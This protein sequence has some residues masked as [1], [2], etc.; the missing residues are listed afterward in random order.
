MNLCIVMGPVKSGTTMFISLLDGHPSLAGFPLEVKFLT[1]WFERLARTPQS[2]QSLNKF[3][4]EKSKIRLMNSGSKSDPDIMNSGRIDF[5]GFDFDL[6]KS[7]MLQNEINQDRRSLSGK[8]LFCQYFHD[9]HEC[10]NQLMGCPNYRLIVSKEGNHGVKYSD[11]INRLCPGSKYIVIVRDPRDVYASFKQIAEKKRTGVVTPTFKDMI[12]PARFIL[13]NKGKNFTAFENCFNTNKGKRDS[14]LFLRYED[15][16]QDSKN[17][18]TRAANFLGIPFDMCLLQ[19]TNLKNVWGGNSSSL[20]SF[21]GLTDSR[22]GKWQAELTAAEKRLI[23]YFLFG[24]LATGNYKMASKRVSRTQIVIDIAH[25][26]RE[27]I[28]ASKWVP[29]KRLREILKTL[30]Y[31]INATILCFTIKRRER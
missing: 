16:V 6:F 1:H 3:F 4:L 29:R 28:R 15:I 10:L 5:A 23:E 12:T 30:F 14:Y 22:I 17:E 25:T 31:T 21:S 13:D 26:E 11:S 7:G 19:P 8:R 2:Y 20:R 9:I 27:A 18:L 24:Y